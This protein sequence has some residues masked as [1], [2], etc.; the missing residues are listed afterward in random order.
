MQYL[1][2]AKDSTDPDT[3]GRRRS[4]RER[5]LA[6]IGPL[7]AS[8]I[9]TLGGAILDEHQDPVGSAILIEADSI[10][11]VE[12]ILERDIYRQEGVWDRFEIYPFR[13]AV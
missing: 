10:E 9:V 5:H 13:R 3:L 1:V 8:G 6:E 7:V 11:D 12:E 4:V 2:I